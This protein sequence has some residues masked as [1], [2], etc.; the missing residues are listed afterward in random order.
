MKHAQASRADRPDLADRVALRFST[1]RYVDG[2][3]IGT[4]ESEPE[5]ILRRIE[6]ALSL[7]KHY[8]RVRYDRLIRD[9][10]RVWVISIHPTRW[11]ESFAR[12][13]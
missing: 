2:L 3:W 10:K 9:L 13:S 7:I 1:S 5:P 8:D 4:L 11:C 6:E 12:C